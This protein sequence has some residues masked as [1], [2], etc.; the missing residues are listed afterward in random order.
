MLSPGVAQTIMDELIYQLPDDAVK[1]WDPE[2]KRWRAVP[3]AERY[4]PG[5]AAAEAA[6]VELD[7]FPRTGG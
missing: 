4:R 1:I 7:A 5:A 2:Q 3:R 6:A